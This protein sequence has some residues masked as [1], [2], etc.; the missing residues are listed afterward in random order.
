MKM[1]EYP[2]EI[3]TLAALHAAK[4]AAAAEEVA[5]AKAADLAKAK[6]V[7]AEEVAALCG[8]LENATSCEEVAAIRRRLGGKGVAASTAATAQTARKPSPTP[9]P[10]SPKEAL[11]VLK[12]HLS[13]SQLEALERLEG[14][15]DLVFGLQQLEDQVGLLAQ[16]RDALKGEL[17]T[18][19]KPL[20]ETPEEEEET[21]RKPSPTTPAA[22]AAEERRRSA[23]RHKGLLERAGFTS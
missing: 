16:E 13:G 2:S 12:Q 9:T 10:T 23:R 1:E 4:V 22:P 14:G 7:A 20:E 15:E 19:R 8:D 17:E 3:P 6:S 11:K 18:A 5:A 21:A